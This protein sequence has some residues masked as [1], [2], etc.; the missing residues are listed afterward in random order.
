[1]ARAKWTVMVYLAGDNDLSAAG[2]RDLDEMRRVGSTPDVHVVAQFD[3]AGAGS[4]RRFHLER[5]GAGEEVVALGETDSGDPSVLQAFVRWATERYPADHYALVLWNHGGGWAPAEVGERGA[6]P[7]GRVLFRSS[8]KRILSPSSAAER[9]IL[10]DDGSGHSLDTVELGGVLATIAGDLGRPLDVL[11]LDACLMSCL[12]VAYEASP[13]V[14][15]MVASE[16]DEP[17][18]GWPYAALLGALVA[19]PELPARAAGAKIVEQYVGDFRQRGYQGD[20]TLAALDL[21]RLGQLVGRLDDLVGALLQ[22]PPAAADVV[23]TAQRR[24][25]SFC[26][27]TQWDLA[28]LAENIAR[29]AAGDPVRRAAEAVVE[30]IRGRENGPTIASEQSGPG[31]AGCGG[32]AVYLPALVRVSPYYKELAFAR[33][34]R[35]PGWLTQYREALSGR[36][37]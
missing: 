2:D 27:Q 6:T 18:D 32:L 16:E 21:K 9:A 31:V 15:V 12:E 17:A 1:M 36:R 7:L 20:V 29:G 11:G 30:Q 34:S 19:N 22:D 4:T 24:T 25:P 3:R 5:G 26:R 33:D 28:R 23:W 14:E 13:Y 35:W 10:S 8:R 37:P